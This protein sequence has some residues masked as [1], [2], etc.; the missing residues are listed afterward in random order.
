MGDCHTF[1]AVVAQLKHPNGP[2]PPR[3][4]RAGALYASPPQTAQLW[5]EGEGDG[6]GEPDSAALICCRSWPTWF[7]SLW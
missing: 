6:A 2:L 1:R 5:G 4:V 7:I 3:L